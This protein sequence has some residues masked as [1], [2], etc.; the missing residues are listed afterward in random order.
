[1]R[2][3]REAGARVSG[4]RPLDSG[5]VQAPG[6]VWCTQQG[7]QDGWRLF[8]TAVGPGRP[9]DSC[10]GYILSAFSADGLAF[11]KDPG[12][13]LAPRPGVVHGSRRLLAPAVVP[14]AHPSSGQPGF[15]MYVESRGEADVPTV[16]TSAWSVDLLHWTHEAGIRLHGPGGVSVRCPR[17]TP[18]SPPASARSDAESGRRSVLRMMVVD[19]NGDVLSALSQDG[20]GLDFTLEPGVRFRHHPQG[21][22]RGITAADVIPAPRGGLV[23]SALLFSAWTPRLPHPVGWKYPPHLPLPPSQGGPLHPS[24]DPATDHSRFAELSIASD[25]DGFR[26]RIFVAREVTPATIADATSYPVPQFGTVPTAAHQRGECVVEGGGYG[27]DDID[28][29]HAE[30][31]CWTAL[32]DGRIRIYYASC[33]S[34]GAWQIA[35]CVTAS[36]VTTKPAEEANGLSNA[37]KL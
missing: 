6:V 4:D 18:L 20:S 22:H 31:M 3:E 2:W 37:S 8:Y 25:L 36:C 11:E 13:R 17:I 27:S 1:M 10:Q 5:K 14:A 34:L 21:D 32:P 15:R 29:V 23:G 33:D 19:G 12:I 35:S 7:G 16:V 26:S 9:F 24:M 28:A 30:D